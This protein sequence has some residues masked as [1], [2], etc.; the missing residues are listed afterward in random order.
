MFEQHSFDP[1]FR[2]DA[3][4][5]KFLIKGGK[6]AVQTFCRG[7]FEVDDVI[8]VQR[9]DRKFEDLQLLILRHHHRV[10]RQDREWCKDVCDFNVFLIKIF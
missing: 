6:I 9:H 10:H 4:H 2:E 5:E 7:N 3:L 8:N 1:S